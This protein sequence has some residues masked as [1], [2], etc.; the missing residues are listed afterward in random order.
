M[1]GGELYVARAGNQLLLSEAHCTP[2]VGVTHQTRQLCF[3][4]RATRGAASAVST[5]RVRLRAQPITRRENASSTTRRRRL[6][7]PLTVS[8]SNSMNTRAACPV[9]SKVPLGLFQRPR[10]HLL[11]KDIAG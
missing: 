9:S 8:C 4:I 6:Q 11:A 1:V 3:S 5:S 2:P 7:L 10:D